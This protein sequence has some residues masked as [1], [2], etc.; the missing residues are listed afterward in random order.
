[1]RSAAEGFVVSK[2]FL[3]IFSKFMFLQNTQESNL[4]LT[5]SLKC[6]LSK[7]IPL[8]EGEASRN[9]GQ[10]GTD[11]A[12][13]VVD[14]GALCPVVSGCDA[15]CHGNTGRLHSAVHGCSGLT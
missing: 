15:W 14:Y 6:G 8:E 2:C 3:L 12:A 10:L 1:M 9:R 5:S 4:C 11:A 7:R 13:D